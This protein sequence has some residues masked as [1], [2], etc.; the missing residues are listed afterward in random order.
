VRERTD[1]VE[2]HQVRP[3]VGPFRVSLLDQPELPLTPPT[4]QALFEVD[5]VTGVVVEA[6]PN[7]R[8]EI[9]ALREPLD[10]ALAM[11]GCA[12]GKVASHADVE[13]AAAGVGHDVDR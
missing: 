12:V 2:A 4:L 9:V 8:F 3:K 5:R 13:H 1:D 7:Q 10:L 11:L 6:I